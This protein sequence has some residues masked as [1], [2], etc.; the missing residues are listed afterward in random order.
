MITIKD[1]K[2]IY[3]VDLKYYNTTKSSQILI[4]ND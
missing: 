2:I 3:I 4:L 1:P